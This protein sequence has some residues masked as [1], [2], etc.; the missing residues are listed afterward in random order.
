[1]PQA[2]EVHRGMVGRSDVLLQVRARAKAT[3]VSH[4]P[5]RVR[6]AGGGA[7]VKR[8]LERHGALGTAS[9]T[10]HSVCF[11]DRRSGE[12]ELRR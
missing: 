9:P 5:C 8:S 2:A 7:L 1:M 11:C 12:A 6:M 10:S 3:S 4:Q